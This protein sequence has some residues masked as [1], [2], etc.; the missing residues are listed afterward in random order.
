MTAAS[1]AFVLLGK[2]IDGT[3]AEPVS[4]GAVAVMGDQI[5]WAGP[6]DELPPRWTTEGTEVIDCTGRCILPG[7]VDAHTHL[8][9]GEAQSEEELGIY[10]SVEYRSMLAGYH[11]AKVLKAGVTSASEAASTYSISVALRDAIEAGIV[12]GPR[13]SAAGRQITTHQGLEDPF[14]SWV[15]FQPGVPGTLVRNRDEILE[16]VRLQVKDGIDLIKVS[17]SA[18]A[19]LSNEP[20]SGAAF[21]AEEFDLLADEVHRLERHC[22]VHARTAES[23]K[24]SAR[25]GF[26][27]IFHASYMDEEGLDLVGERG[28]PLVPTLTLLFNMVEAAQGTVGV[29]VVDVFKQEIDAASEILSRARRLGV[30]IIAGSESGLSLVPFG[31]WHARELEIFVTHLGMSPLEAIRAG[32]LAAARTLP[33]WRDKIGSIEQGKRADLLVVNGD[34]SVDIT[35]L[36]QPSKIDMVFKD[37]RIVDPTPVPDRRVL[38]F[39][40]TRI[41]LAGRFVYDEEAQ[42][43]VVL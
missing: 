19:A 36:Q 5:D 18:D 30:E 42:R 28:I 33:R 8:S 9:F 35:V 40:R 15:P 17:G 21:R 43:G 34:P 20:L 11:A 38:P 22:A 6:A 32:T 14:P 12:E 2:V 27:W 26:D 7:L 4:A 1:D 29:S 3:G 16:A 31:Q 41:F 24:L 10:T 39:E 37:G 23:V 25:A 13:L